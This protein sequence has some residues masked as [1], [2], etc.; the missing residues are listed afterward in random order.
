LTSFTYSPLRTDQIRL[1][2]PT[3]SDD[4]LA[5]SV[6]IV[7]LESADLHFD[8]LSY[9]WGSQ[10]EMYSI[11]CSGRL[12]QV[13]YNLFTALPFLARRTGATMPRPLWIDAVCINQADEKEKLNQ[14]RLMNTLYQRATKVWIWLG[15]APPEVQRYIPHAIALLPHLVEE[16]KRRKDMLRGSRT[17][18]VNLPLRQ[19]EPDLWKAILHLARNPYY[20]RVWVVQEVALAQQIAVLCGEDEIDYSLLEAVIDGDTMHLWKMSDYFGEPVDIPVSTT[21]SST[22]FLIRWLVQEEAVLK[23]L[24]TP[25]MLLRI[26]IIMSREHE[27]FLAQDRVFGMLGLIKEKE[28]EATGIDVSAH[29]TVTSVYTQFSTY[30]LLNTS[31]NET[32]NWWRYFNLAFTLKRP[33]E[34]PSWVPDLHHQKQGAAEYVCSPR[35]VVEFIEVWPLYHKYQASW[36]PN[37]IRKGSGSHELILCGKILDRIVFVHPPIPTTP[38]YSTIA[39]D[40]GGALMFLVKLH[41]WGV[42]IA[43]IV[44]RDQVDNKNGTVIE[45]PAGPRISQ[46]TYWMTLLAG[47]QA[48]HDTGATIDGETWRIYCRAMEQAST[49]ARGIID[50]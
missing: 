44:L 11:A 31:P 25:Y 17:E 20:R 22:I 3:G 42:D 47:N 2:S 1:L 38:Q 19:L 39:D 14:I 36:K 28:L 16:A 48:A 24:R 46:D 4:G 7:S 49:V 21:D 40:G 37:A 18:E 33:L 6:Q 23:D 30:I 29:T 5:W 9:T 34:L 12:M 8:A 35:R 32:E 26:A 45:N 50:G 27:C 41:E 43:N 13:H 10:V 15:C